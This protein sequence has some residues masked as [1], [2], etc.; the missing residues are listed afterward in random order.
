M[1]R[2]PDPAKE[3][4]L[5]GLD[6][7]GRAGQVLPGESDVL[8]L[9]VHLHAARL[10]PSAVGQIPPGHDSQAAFGRR[11]L[12]VGWTS[13]RMVDTQLSVYTHPSPGRRKWLATAEPSSP[14]YPAWAVAG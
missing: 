13:P 12:R 6:H 5:P 3:D 2:R 9:G 14:V 11:H 10:P 1:P 4:F 7:L 8:A